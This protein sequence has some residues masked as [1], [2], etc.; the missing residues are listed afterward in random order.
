MVSSIPEKQPSAEISREELTRLVVSRVSLKKAST[1]LGRSY[2]ATRKLV[3]NRQLVHYKMGGVT[4]VTLYEIRRFLARG[5][6]TEADWTESQTG[7]R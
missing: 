3:A 7:D 2:P 5:N 1:L 6:A 4:V